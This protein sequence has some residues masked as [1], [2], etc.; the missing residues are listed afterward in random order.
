MEKASFKKSS[1]VKKTLDLEI[2][3][4]YKNDSVI[5]GLDTFILNSVEELEIEPSKKEKIRKTFEN[6]KSFE[7]KERERAIKETIHLLFEAE[8]PQGITSLSITDLFTPVQYVKGIGPKLARILEKIGIKTTYDL[9]FYFPRDYIDL[10]SLSKI[11]TLSVGE[12]VTVKV[13]VINTS[14][15]SAGRVRIFIALVSDGTG[16]IKATWFNQPY[17]KNII[18][19]GVLLILHGHVQYAYGSWELP[20]P[21]YEIIQEGKETI[22]SMRIIPIYPLTQGISQKTI[23]GRV[24]AAIDAYTGSI[25]D[26][27]EESLKKRLNLIGLG[28]AIRNIHF[29]EDFEMLEKA[30]DRLIFNELFELQ[31]L[32]G[33]RKRKVKE[34]AGLVFKIEE[35]DITAF[36]K[37]L[38]FTL[39]NDQKAAIKDIESDLTGGKPANRLLHGDVGSGKTVIALFAVFIT[40]KNSY[41]SAM[42][43]PTEI[44]AQQTFNVAES[45]LR[46]TGMRIKLLTSGIKRKEREEILSEL[47]EGKIDLLVGTHALIEEDVEFKRLGLVIVDEQH[48]FGVIQRSILRKKGEIPHTLVMSATPI[49]RTL[50]LT[51]YGD[52]DITQLREL[53]KGRKPVLTK[54]CVNDEE[55]PYRLLIEELNQGR[56]GYVVCPLIE[57]SDEIELQA[58]K[59][60]AEKLKENYLKNFNIGVLY[61]SMKSEEK[62][63]IMESFRN[64]K[65]QVLVSTT[66]V[67]VGVDV[68]DAT[69][70]IVEDADRFGLSTL[71]QLRGRVGRSGLQSYCYLITRNPEGDAIRRLKVLEKTNNGFEVAEE[72]L[73]IRGPGEILG[74]RQHGLPEFKITTL[75]RKKDLE[76][77]ELARIE[78]FALVEGRSNFSKE[79][80]KELREILKAKFGDKVSL[81][82]VA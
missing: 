53:P 18:K 37:L 39:T 36:E 5:G 77:L 60:L 47:K 29:P 74:T 24:K 66:V 19:E 8:L 78:A 50:A 80:E 70:I 35:K 71:H 23:R 48:R 34:Q 49:P 40:S 55:R 17:L 27:L 22:H 2:K 61:G 28:E 81:I 82:E 69:I 57:A 63:D 51:L 13:K 9:L 73:K 21:E 68:P 65:V 6:Y 32:L 59:S 12:D 62:K 15:R 26:Y 33:T 56:K 31:F 67:E 58:V 25:K 76:L 20:S 11:A 64:G 52:L 1:F 4:E 3:K 16:Y 45:L 41:Q 54:V 7:V 43:S 30:K 46:N 72:D 10:R 44:L 14:E 75:M 79:M 38:P 42:M